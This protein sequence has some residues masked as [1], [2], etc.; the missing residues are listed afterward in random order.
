LQMS[1][2]QWHFFPGLLLLLLLIVEQ[3]LQGHGDFRVKLILSISVWTRCKPGIWS[4]SWPLSFELF[5]AWG[6]EP[7]H[8]PSKN[9]SYL[10]QFDTTYTIYKNVENFNNYFFQIKKYC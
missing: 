10:G 9:P 6:F 4:K 1:R 5:F 8:F 3:A 2:R 7:I